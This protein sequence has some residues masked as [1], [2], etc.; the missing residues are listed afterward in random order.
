MNFAVRGEP[1]IAY[2]NEDAIPSHILNASI[3]DHEDGAA[4]CP[5][6]VLC[7]AENQP[8]KTRSQS[9]QTTPLHSARLRQ[10]LLF[11]G[12]DVHLI[13]ETVS[14][15]FFHDDERKHENV[16]VERAR[17]VDAKTRFELAFKYAI[18]DV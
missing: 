2:D 6:R 15:L 3:Y 11:S 9:H 7:V 13:P 10:V 16:E 8:K 12:G 14:S 5:N 18:C 4:C 1:S 17:W